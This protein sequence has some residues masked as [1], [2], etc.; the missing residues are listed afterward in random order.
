[1]SVIDLNDT[2][3]QSERFDLDAIKDRLC[4]TAA[5]WLPDLFPQARLSQDR[6]ALRCADLS[7]RPPR[8]EGSCVI[9]LRGPRAGWGFDYATGESAGPI[10]LIAWSTGLSSVPLFKEA[11]RL[12]RMD[13]RP[14][15]KPTPRAAPAPVDHSLEVA[16]LVSG[17][18]PLPGTVGAAY[19]ASR[20]IAAADLPDLRFHADLPDF[21]TKRGWPGLVG[22]VRDAAGKAIGG[23]HRTFLLEDGSDKAPPG[24]K[25]LGPVAGGAVRLG[26]VGPDGR[27]G[28]AE[29]IE[30]ALSAS[31]IFGLPV[32]AGLSADGV[33]RFAWPSDVR[34]V[35][36][37]RDAGEAGLASATALG[38]RLAASGVAFDVA[39]PIHGDDFNDDLRRGAVAADYGPPPTPVGP[40]R[41]E[42]FADIHGAAVLLTKPVDQAAVGAVLG[43]LAQARLDP[44]AER[45]ILAS[46]KQAC[47]VSVAVL[48]KQVNE[49]RKRVSA[50]GE[51]V[52][53]IVR[54]VWTTQLTQDLSGLPERN[55]ANV[56]VALENDPAFA[57]S[58]VFD[59]F[60]MHINV[61]RR[62]PWDEVATPLPRPWN[63]ADDTRFAIWLQKH[64]LNVSPTMAGRTM[65]AYAQEFPVHPVR[66]YLASLTW[67]GVPRLETWA[68]RYLGADDTPLHR[69]FGALWM[70]SAVARVS[71][72][73]QGET[74]KVDHML[75]LEGPQGARKSSA[76]R[77]LG[78]EWFTDDLAEIGSKDAS[79]QLAGV[80]IIEIAE[81]DVMGR[82]ETSRIKA[83]VSREA[84]RFRLPYGRHVIERPRECVFA[85]TVNHATYMKD[86]T[87]NRRFWPV[88]VGAIDLE[89][90]ALDR[91][92]LW[93]EAVH[94]FRAGAVWWLT[95]PAL[96]AAAKDAQGER[97]QT[98]AWDG[99]IEQWLTHERSVDGGWYTR[100]E[101]LND[102]SIGEVLRGAIGLPPERWSRAE[103]MRV[104]TWLK[105]AGWERYRTS[106]NGGREW[107]YRT[108]PTP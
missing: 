75:V 12:A 36:I 45:T 96:I 81:L 54:P 19:L 83:F 51:M 42:T 52:A 73:R 10:D 23:L 91:D 41:L 62:M 88:R 39:A 31:Q 14:K 61:V 30:T 56:M 102:L 25:M 84:E 6:K 49:L 34:H 29:G 101:P 55:E 72:T 2:A 71:R 53:R 94:H 85:G 24:K 43:A 26:P 57:G 86:E 48:E 87:G 66:D 11:Q 74:V 28:I 7:G 47:G 99:L 50:G 100:N 70:I 92:Q 5:S 8:N 89:D 64:G 93:A 46:V 76:L 33:R 9:N 32:W 95:D 104:S 35:T 58:I 18:Q 38:E 107:R 44:L 21:D 106:A 80:W 69:A 97:Y 60:A 40:R 15:F 13:S 22:I 98:D 17:A 105:H 1:M 78:G 37:Y 103:Q 3:V 20:S 67:D 4:D 27:L 68:C 77:V 16:R 108:V 90:L 59:L 65:L 63:D 79:Q 82:A